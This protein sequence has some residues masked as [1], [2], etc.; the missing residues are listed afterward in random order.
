MVIQI[1]KKEGRQYWVKKKQTRTSTDGI[2]SSQNVSKQSQNEDIPGTAAKKEDQLEIFGSNKNIFVPKNTVSCD[3][4]GNTVSNIDFEVTTDNHHADSS[5]VTY[6]HVDLL[7]SFFFIALKSTFL[8]LLNNTAMLYY[9]NFHTSASSYGDQIQDGNNGKNHEAVAIK[10]L[11]QRIKT[12]ENSNKKL[13]ERL[14]N[15]MCF[16][17]VHKNILKN[18]EKVVFYTRVP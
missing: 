10:Y 7:M 3:K 16:Q 15:C 2:S 4:L 14:K 12:L 17:Y 8:L 1:L 5:I 6:K 18:D 13:N 11:V 9:V